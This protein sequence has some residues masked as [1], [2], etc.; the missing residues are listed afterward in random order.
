MARFGHPDTG[1]V[2]ATALIMAAKYAKRTPL[3]LTDEQQTRRAAAA[4]RS[5]WNADIEQRKAD[6]KRAKRMSPREKETT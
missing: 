1:L 6:K 4:D 3:Q 2:A 5:A